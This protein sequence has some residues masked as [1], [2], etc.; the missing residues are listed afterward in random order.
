MTRRT[1][2][3]RRPRRQHAATAKGARVRAE[4]AHVAARLMAEESIHDFAE[5]KLR[6]AD[7]LAV[8]G[9]NSLPRNDEIEAE[10]RQYQALFQ[11][12][13]QPLWLAAKRRV[14]LS[15]I[16][17]LA[18][19]EPVLAGAVLRGT[20]VADAEITL[21]VFAEPPE[22]VARFLIDRDIPWTLDAAQVR[23][24]NGVEQELAVYR[25]SADGEELRLVVFPDDGPRIP[26]RSPVDGRPMRRA[27]R[28]EIERLLEESDDTASAP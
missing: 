20:A 1:K 19:F 14:A 13:T 18:P 28:A 26:P 27:D 12:D 22:M 8:E 9:R 10:L 7:R 23:F 17:L 16:D 2:T 5:A 6:A 21:H 11:A 4:V 25:I 15:V 3:E 24:G